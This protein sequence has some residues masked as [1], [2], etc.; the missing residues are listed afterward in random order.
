[1]PHY[2]DG[3]PAQIGDIVKGTVYNEGRGQPVVGTMVSITPGTDSCNCSVAFLRDE[4]FEEAHKL[5]SSNRSTLYPHQHP[6]EAVANAIQYS[7]KLLKLHRPANHP[8]DA[9]PRVLSMI[10]D[11]SECKALE[12]LYR[13]GT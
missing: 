9:P 3:T 6:G 5:D 13:P 4:S 8:A 2:K 7:G 12:L 10:V 11:Y 1:M